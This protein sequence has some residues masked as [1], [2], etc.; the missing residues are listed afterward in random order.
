MNPIAAALN[1]T[2]ESANPHVLQMLSDVGRELFFPKGILSQGAEAKV[3][4][5]HINATIG[6]ATEKDHTM[7]LPS[8]M[9]NLAGLLPEEV[10]TYAPSYGLPAL[11]QAWQDEIVKKNPDLNDW[12]ISMPVV[13]CGITHG[14]SVFADLF[15]QPNDVIVLPDMM[16]GNY[17]MIFG[18]RKGAR[19]AQYPLFND[20]GGFNLAGFEET[21]AAVAKD[22]GKVI[23]LL[24]FPQNPSGYTLL[25]DEGL[26]VAR[27]LTHTAESGANV[28]AVTDDSYFGLFYEDQIL[29]SSLFALLCGK[30][31]RL[32]A[33]KIDGATKEDYVWGLRVGFVTYGCAAIS[34]HSESLSALYEALE[35]KTGGAVRGSI[36]NASHL[37]QSVL[38]KAMQNSDYWTEK[39][40]KFKIM[41]ARA[42]RVKA[43]LADSRY[44]S[45]WDV[46]PFNSGY[47]M[48][49]R[50][51]E[52]SAE[53]L[54]LHL[55]DRYGIGLIALGERNLRIA[56]SCL[57]E[58]QITELFDTIFQGIQE[59]KSLSVDDQPLRKN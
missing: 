47:F 6:I 42:L 26:A 7:Y 50:L 39:H 52:V 54:R 11:R 25:Q 20:A 21:V 12:P 35:K 23:A 9:G 30:H 43:V 5:H 56:F 45:A 16:W 15:V 51:K 48:C 1:Q 59:I 31:P 10:L 33:V 49:L 4:A 2:I 41:K 38:L 57:E 28:L 37:S 46:Y 55:L 32:M 17:Q 40:A 14:I 58:N 13:T 18:V 22:R 19:I 3:K 8:V 53:A 24:N 34:E 29:Q 44:A 27:I 36:S